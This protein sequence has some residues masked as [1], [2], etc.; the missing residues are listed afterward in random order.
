MSETAQLIS[1]AVGLVGL[2]GAAWRWGRPKWREF[3]KDV[4]S[5][6]DTLIGRDPIIDTVTKAV[7]TEKRPS[8]GELQA[9]T[10]RK[11]EYAI[12]KLHVIEH[13]VM[14]NDGSSLKDSVH[15]IEG[16]LASGDDRFERIEGQ[17][18]EV[19]TGSTERLDR[20]EDI[21][22]TLAEGQNLVWPAI[23]AAVESTPADPAT[24]GS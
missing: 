20:F 15:R 6:R 14:N 5:V 9:E 10:D 7:L 8:I 2:L 23:K 3:R 17:M 19:L 4:I 16:R 13:E 18:D 22:R 21:L 12:G 24:P 11:V 1:I